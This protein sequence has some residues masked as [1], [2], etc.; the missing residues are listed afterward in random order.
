MP[1]FLAW[2]QQQR[3]KR[4][5]CWVAPLALSDNATIPEGRMMPHASAFSRDMV[6]HQSPSGL[7]IWSGNTPRIARWRGNV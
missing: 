4:C 7:V 6:L 5:L 1:I 3:R 2:I